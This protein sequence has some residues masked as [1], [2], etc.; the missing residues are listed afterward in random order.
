LF[1]IAHNLC[2]DFLRHRGVQKV[3]ETA[4]LGPDSV[5]PQQPVGSD[6]GVA[7]EHL[8]TTLPPKERACV[9]LKDVF[10]YSLEEI[11]EMVDSTV[12]GVKAALNR[13]RTK[14]AA[15][16]EAQSARNAD[17]ELEG[18]LRLYVDRFNRHDWDG[19][20]ELV[21]ADARLL[22]ANGFA[23]RLADSPYFVKY[24]EVD[25]PWRMVLGQVDGEHVIIRLR[26]IDSV[27]TAESVI[28][29]EVAN[30]QVVRIV[31]Y[32]WCPWV[33]PAAGSVVI[34]YAASP[35]GS[36]SPKARA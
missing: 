5:P 34:G 13:A 8:V 16:P 9:L 32:L 6:V 23:G 14:L 28:R 24:D 26:P 35:A 10:D 11:A 25:L 4:G 27:W 7:I 12:G 31:D 2:I 30:N 1:R 15:S 33:L 21:S 29:L 18:I 36:V 22:F 19:V 17:P 3:A 20:R